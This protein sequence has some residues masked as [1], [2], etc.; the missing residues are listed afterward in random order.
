MFDF[1]F[2]NLIPIMWVSLLY[3]NLGN[4]LCMH[5]QA[6]RN[7][8]N[9]GNSSTRNNIFTIK[10]FNH[11]IKLVTHLMTTTTSLVILPTHFSFLAFEQQGLLF[12]PLAYLSPHHH[13]PHLL[14][15][16]ILC[17]NSLS[18]FQVLRWCP[19]IMARGHNILKEDLHLR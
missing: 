9:I 4:F 13:D 8:R 11:M 7:V 18:L 5:L 1:D 19:C 16:L 3:S 15:Y 17:F 14:A 6:I 10:T 2:I 12:L